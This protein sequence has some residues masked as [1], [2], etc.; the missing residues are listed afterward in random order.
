MPDPKKLA[1]AILKARGT[2]GYDALITRTFEAL[3]IKKKDEAEL[4]WKI[5][6][7]ADERACRARAKK[8]GS[9][10]F[11]REVRVL[12]P[13]VA[14]RDSPVR[15]NRDTMA[16]G[17]LN[18]EINASRR[19]ADARAEDIA[20]DEAVEWGVR[21]AADEPQDPKAHEAER[22]R[23]LGAGDLAK[24]RA[25]RKRYEHTLRITTLDLDGQGS[26]AVV[27]LLL[28]HGADPNLYA[29]GSFDSVLAFAQKTN[30]TKIAALL[31]KAGAKLRIQ[32][33]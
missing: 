11:E 16:P 1:A 17:A 31:K 18:L 8:K 23:I 22:A 29:D 21:P 13:V 14:W 3:A 25:Y 9:S 32:K 20:D 30:R 27:A 12:G 15:S 26:E 24:W 5:L 33:K 28:E 4:A 10:F 7:L 6:E 19:G 2:K